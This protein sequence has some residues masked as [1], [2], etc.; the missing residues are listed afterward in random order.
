M[1][2]KENQYYLNKRMNFSI[3]QFNRLLYHLINVRN[4]VFQK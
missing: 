1:T 3:N 2:E 4:D